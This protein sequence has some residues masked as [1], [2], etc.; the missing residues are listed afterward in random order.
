MGWRAIS[1]SIERV[2]GNDWNDAQSLL[3]AIKIVKAIGIANV[4]GN[5]GFTMT[6]KD[7]DDYASLAM[8]VKEASYI[9]KELLR[10]K[11]IRYAEYKKRL[12]LFE[13][14]DV[15]IEEEIAN[16]TMVIPKPINFVDDLRI[17]F[18]NRVSPVKASYYHRGTPRF[19]EYMLL[20]EAMDVAPTG[21]VDG[22]VQMIFST[23]DSYFKELELF[24]M[25]C[26]HAIIFAYFNNTEEI[27]NHLYKIQ[28]YRYIID[29]VLIDKFNDEIKVDFC[30]LI[31]FIISHK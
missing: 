28:K 22:Y 7:M 24:S 17:Y 2:E 14:T 27:V 20:S 18:N 3:D 26:E 12:I 21:D 13:G 31:N 29:K 23:S 10:L 15:N 1:L 30:F 11:I 19:F 8:D 6:S 16:A 9:I 5:G 25:N 4:F